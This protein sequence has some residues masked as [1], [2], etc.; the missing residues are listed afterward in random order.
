MK[1]FPMLAASSK[2]AICGLP[3]RVDS[4]RS[5][6]FGCAYC[7]ANN[8]TI[9]PTSSTLQVG[10]LDGLRDLV[11]RVER[12]GPRDGNF[13]ET[14]MAHGIT[15]HCGGMSDPFQPCE[16]EHHVTRGLVD[17]TREHG[18]HVLFSTK[19]D[20][21]RGC[22]PDPKLHSFQLSVTNVRDRTDLEPGVPPI[23][24]RLRLFHDLK[25]RGFKVGVRIQPFIPRVS[26][27]AIVEAFRDADHFSIEGLK[28]VP[29]NREHVEAVLGMTGLR[30]E[31]FTQM[32]LLNIRPSIRERI[33][34]PTIAAL[35]SR[36]AS[37]SIADN[38]M[39]DVSTC[40]C[41]CGDALV[42][43][44]SGFDTTAMC[45]EHGPDYTLEDVLEAI[46]PDLRRC[47]VRHLFT[48]NRVG[49]CVTVEDF[50]RAHFAVPSSPF[51]PRFLWRGGSSGMG[52]LFD[53][54]EYTIGGDYMV[55]GEKRYREARESSGL[56]PEEVCVKLGISIGTLY[57][58]ESGKTVPGANDVRNMAELYAVSA[59]YLLGID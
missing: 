35:E 25:E 36:G 16:A 40:R 18:I 49:S 14:L 52:T 54:N 33:Y 4:Y 57:N 15:W 43:R 9:M 6:S 26:G 50:Y 59:D 1:T 7:F 39:H 2:F 53:V 32:G 5:C 56:K 28:L 41:C 31:D 37:Y 45:H 13:V 51:S 34:A 24:S 29:Q 10:D 3:L 42:G 8:R 47:K 48:S 55:N 22:K 46:A 27:E 44:S 19:T 58:W 23:M 17:L 20:D 12:S 11:E 38:D 21:L 30:P